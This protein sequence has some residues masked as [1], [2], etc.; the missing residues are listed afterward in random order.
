MK[1]ESRALNSNVAK[2]IFWLFFLSAGIPLLTISLISYHHIS[3]RLE[4]DSSHQIYR[5]SRALGLSIYDRLI[6]LESNLKTIE[7]GLKNN[8][9]VS[10]YA[11]DE[12]LRSIFESVYIK[13]ITGTY[14]TIFGT[15]LSPIQLD[16]KQQNHLDNGNTVLI[17]D[18]SAQIKRIL[19]IRMITNT[20]EDKRYLIGSV[21]TGYLWN[22]GV[23][24]PEILF[25]MDKT[26]K[27]LFSS[28]TLDEKSKKILDRLNLNT[29]DKKN[30]KHWKYN[31]QDYVNN[32]W[33]IFLEANFATENFIVSFSM[34][35]KKV[36]SAVQDFKNIFP[37]TLLVT[38]ILVTLLSISLIRKSL[39]PIEKLMIGTIHVK[40]GVYDKPV[41]IDSGDEFQDLGDSFNNMM[42]QLDEQF[43]TLQ[44]LSKIDR[45]IL[46]SLDKNHIIQTLI[47]YLHELI[48]SNHVCV[49]TI[50][51]VETGQAEMHIN[52]DEAFSEI[53]HYEINID[54][55]ERHELE[56]CDE[57]LLFNISD[58]KSYFKQQKILGDH[59]FLVYPI[60]N[61]N[62]LS[63]LICISSYNMIDVKKYKYKKIRELV[64]RTAVALSNAE[65]EEKLFLQAHF[66]SLSCLP[67]RFLFKDRMEQA[68]EKAKRDKTNVALM[69][70]DLD[71]FKTINDSLG[72][73]I[74]DEVIKEVAVLLSRC[75][76]TYDTVSRFGGDEFLIMIPDIKLV[77]ILIKKASKVA[78]RILERMSNPFVINKRE[79]FVSVSIGIA[80]YPKDA[81]NYGDILLNADVA[82]YKAKEHGRNNYI[83]YDTIYAK[84]T[85]VRLDL[86]NDLRYALERDEFYLMYQPKVEMNTGKIVGVETLIRWHHQKMGLINP[87]D[88][89]NLAEEAGLISN[90]GY[91]V[92]DNACRQI[93][94]WQDEY[95]I[96][97]NV[98]VN[99]SSD[100]FRQA[101][102]FERVYK[103]ISESELAPE[104]LELEITESITIEDTVRTTTLLNEFRELGLTISVDDFGTGYSSLSQLQKFPI[105]NLKIDRS[106]IE[107]IPFNISSI[108]ITGAI[109]ALA[110]NLNMHTIAEGVE[111]IEQFKLL[112]ELNCDQIQGYIISKPLTDIELV[113][114]IKKNKG[115]FHL[116]IEN[117]R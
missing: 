17:I 63:G 50:S 35:E 28:V 24:F 75:V 53:E 37:Q 104:F 108:S 102:L 73:S 8:L 9:D 83:F 65:W 76:R 106:F 32:S 36:F 19:M 18:T 59:S 90:I 92:L 111:S 91:W 101:D 114:Y 103:I 52:L 71:R 94:F 20:S 56:K 93:K 82:M 49:V 54:D 43:K 84:N 47:Q 97:L 16:S 72:H 87:D 80:L 100:Q 116:N 29:A 42:V 41:E 66:D 64:D 79:I 85:L 44:T 78:S 31:K 62:T 55:V 10:V 38:V 27:I 12:W 69:F 34:P 109:I 4:Q 60:S 23:Y 33:N 30:I 2:R 105:D 58:V 110:H 74:G 3:E 25:V 117:S 39:G 14:I 113:K 6:T 11:N 89:I 1:F 5:E 15:N 112:N 61:N 96:K 48:D 86:E 99:L 22:L 51:N 88:F 68:I 26:G 67:N 7:S 45:L 81:D 46:S 57:Y 98:A 77:D 70:I 13:Q 115:Y 95:G 21:A 40:K 107:D